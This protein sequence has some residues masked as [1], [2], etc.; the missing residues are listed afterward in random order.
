MNEAGCDYSHFLGQG[1]NL[2]KEPAIKH[3]KESFIEKVLCEN[4]PG[5]RSSAIKIKLIEFGL[6]EDVC[7]ICEQ[8]PIWNDKKL[9]LQLDHIDGNHSNNRLENFEVVCPNCHTQTETFSGKKNALVM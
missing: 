7:G 6:K 4:G 8:L 3:T 5:W 2:G 1:S 9:V